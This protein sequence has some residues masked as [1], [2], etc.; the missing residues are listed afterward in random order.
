[1]A[2][3]ATA[4][5][6]VTHKQSIVKNT[7]YVKPNL[8]SNGIWLSDGYS[9]RAI[10]TM[11]DTSY[12][13]KVFNG[14]WSSYCNK[15]NEGAYIEICLPQ[16]LEIAGI[17]ISSSDG[18]LPANGE[19][20]YSDNG[21]DYVKCGTWKDILG[22]S[23]SA[24]A[25]I[26]ST[27]GKHRIWRLKSTSRALKH[28]TNNADIS[29]A[30]LWYY[31]EFKVDNTLPE[32]AGGWVNTYLTQIL[33]DG[34]DV[35]KLEVFYTYKRDDL[36]NLW[37]GIEKSEIKGITESYVTHRPHSGLDVRQLEPYINYRP[38]DGLDIRQ[39]DVYATVRHEDAI[40]TYKIPYGIGGY[41]EAFALY[42][43]LLLAGFLHNFKEIKIKG[44]AVEN[45]YVPLKSIFTFNR[46]EMINN[47]TEDLETEVDNE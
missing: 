3:V 34:L 29:S 36:I 9:C 6:F 31:E 47:N 12:A 44:V 26:D 39:L 45:H 42:R 11:S 35:R 20:Y 43:V 8:S 2:L 40:D 14:G 32:G 25:T 46:V 38:H 22:T 5:G 28:P 13:Y 21:E 17:N 7:R 4:E 16:P 24:T 30:T 33:H 15:F 27:T 23:K 1:M 10:S 18:Y 41:I 37:E 19:V